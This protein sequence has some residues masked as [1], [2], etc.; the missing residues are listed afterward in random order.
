MNKRDAG[1][2]KLPLPQP[3]SPNHLDERILGY[4]RD[5]VPERRR[6]S[7]PAWIGGLATAGVL[8]VALFITQP[9]APA[10]HYESSAP[11]AKTS[12]HDAVA[13]DASAGSAAQDA[14]TRAP[15]SPPDAA[16]LQFE[17]RLQTQRAERS[18]GPAPEAPAVGAPERAAQP[19]PPASAARVL[20][21]SPGLAA[22]AAKM[23]TFYA[24][25]LTG[26]L[27]YCADLLEDDEE[28]RAR[29]CYATLRRACL[30]CNLPE[31]LEAALAER[32]AAQNASDPNEPR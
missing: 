1:D 32:A 9:E 20:E 16:P 28:E 22:S 18:A 29:D 2:K 8:V 13:D 23:E 7:R 25:Q 21:E 10:P 17:L 5:R 6:I 14:A 27:D 12:A 19:E 24:D 26:S 30:G 31:T 15:A 3:R 4:A 11:A